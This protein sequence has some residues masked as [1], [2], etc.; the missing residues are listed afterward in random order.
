MSL[1]G[2]LDSSFL[3]LLISERSRALHTFSIADRPDH[4]DLLQAQAI[5]TK[6]G[7]V[8]HSVVMTFD[9]YLSYIPGCVASSQ[10]PTSLSI[11][12]FY[13]LCKTAA[14]YVSSCM[15]GEGADALLGGDH[16]YLCRRSIC[17][18]DM[19]ALLATCGLTLSRRVTRLISELSTAG[20]FEKYVERLLV[21]KLGESLEHHHLGLVDKC[22]MAWTVETLFPYI[23]DN[24]VELA[25]QLPW[26]FLVRSDLGI[27]KYLLKRLCFRR[28]GQDTFDIILRT[29][30]GI[31]SA[32]AGLWHRFD[33]LCDTALPPDYLT[34][35]P[36][37]CCFEKKRQLLLF[38]LFLEIAMVHHGSHI[39]VGCISGFLE[40]IVKMD[41]EISSRHRELF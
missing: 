1:S 5:A 40:R 36:L 39:D 9:E 6:I 30:L 33:N 10:Q 35:H 24:V 25:G 38:D 12:P 34:R 29:K 18:R 15:V 27:G 20:S 28:F 14:G 13:V 16:D 41:S 21:Y 7:S 8:H 3:A 37:G 11:L 4:S 19:P 23:D 17:S 31:P 22:A 32:A 2:G 26:N